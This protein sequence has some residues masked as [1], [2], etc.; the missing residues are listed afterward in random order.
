MAL[1]FLSKNQVNSYSDSYM[2]CKSISF[3]FLENQIAVEFF[4]NFQII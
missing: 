4:K 3:L 2:V 1:E